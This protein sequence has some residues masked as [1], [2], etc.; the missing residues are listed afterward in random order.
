MKTYIASLLSASISAAN[1]ATWIG[2]KATA[3][4]LEARPKGTS[5]WT[6]TSEEDEVTVTWTT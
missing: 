3:G 6:G 1:V 4:D 5:S 2:T